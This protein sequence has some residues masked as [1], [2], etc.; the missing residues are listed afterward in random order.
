MERKAIVCPSARPEDP[1]AVVIGVVH[2]DDT[3]K[4]VEM[5]PV[6]LPLA[7][8]ID[9]IPGTLRSTEVVRLSAPCVR[10][11]CAHFVTD[12]CSLA[13]RVT[14]QLEPVSDRL[15]PCVIRPTCR[16]FLQEREAACFR[17][18][19]VVTEPFL[20]DPAMVAVARPPIAGGS[21][22]G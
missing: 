19:A 3:A 11:A 13:E 6:A 7:T 12:R 14:T 21:I 2:S 15:A 8:F 17:C 22:H 18:P 1:R 16:W 5:L 10:G 20:V 4:T 9:L